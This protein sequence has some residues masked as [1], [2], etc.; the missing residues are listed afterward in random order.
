MKQANVRGARL[1]AVDQGRGQPL[2]LLH[3]FPLDH[4][5]WRYQIE[6]LAARCRVIAP[7]LR[8]FGASPA[9]PGT[10]TMAA[11]ADD[12][13]ELLDGLAIHEPVVLAGLSMGGYVALEFWRRHAAR[14]AGLV[15][16][17]TRSAADS[18]E[19]AA[20]RRQT[21]ERVLGGGPAFLA[22]AMLPRLLAPETLA[23]RADIVAELRRTIESAD[24]EGVAAASRGM[25]ERA[26]A[27]PWLGEIKLPTLVV[28]GRHDAI[29]TVE[30]MGQ[31]AAAIGGARLAEIP[32][33]GHMSPL[34]NPA[35]VNAA[36][37]E[38]LRRAGLV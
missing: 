15:L 19:A 21:A 14:L 3:G 22:E 27:T 12:V 26:D 32:A 9:T 6:A 20:T 24:P 5:M 37:E 30:E 1:A 10:L 34:E 33:A 13:A 38:F 2:V 8:G 36:L 29:S 16:C 35:A 17:D 11:M 31:I 18:A 7:D 4:T 23:G 28:V 25:A